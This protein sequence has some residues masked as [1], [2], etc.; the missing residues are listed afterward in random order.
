MPAKKGGAKK[1]RAPRP[2][3]NAVKSYVDRA[4]SRNTENKRITTNSGYLN[5][6]NTIS[7]TG[8][9][10][11]TLPTINQGTKSYERIGTK[12]RIKK[13]VIRGHLNWEGTST[14]S[15]QKIGV[16]MML[17]KSKKV[18]NSDAASVAAELPYLLEAGGGSYQSFNGE[19]SDLHAPI[20]KKAFAAARDKKIYMFQQGS[21]ADE[22]NRA[23]KFFTMDI[24]QARNKVVNYEF[25]TGTPVNFG[26]YLSFGWVCLDGNIVA[27]TNYNLGV[28][29]IVDVTYED[30]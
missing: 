21:G 1:R 2:V 28:N 13:M 30:A 27:T 12:I 6:N 19:V 14:A 5:F 29:Y 15:L 8:D 4:I 26:W 18:P 22:L 16:R 25:E 23:V 7:A 20:N 10:K 24:K 11:F 3:S 9:I 17:L